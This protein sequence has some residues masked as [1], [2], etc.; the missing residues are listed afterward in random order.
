MSLES[1]TDDKIHGDKCFTF[2]GRLRPR[3]RPRDTERVR[4]GRE[5]KER[6]K[7]HYKN[8][9]S[10]APKEL[11]EMQHFRSFTHDNEFKRPIQTF[12]TTN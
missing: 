8:S 12:L 6:Q 5:K 4:E 7:K 1:N 2:R 10:I 9:K 3:E 11:N